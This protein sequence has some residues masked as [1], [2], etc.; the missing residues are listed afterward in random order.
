MLDNGEKNKHYLET[1]GYSEN[2]IRLT[3]GHIP[4]ASLETDFNEKEILSH[5][6][7]FDNIQSV[8]LI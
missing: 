1:K 6:R 4:L 5:L 7:N 3:T 2:D 8:N